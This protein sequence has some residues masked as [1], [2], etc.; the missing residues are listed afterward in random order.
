M[1]TA[2][3]QAGEIVGDPT[4][5]SKRGLVNYLAWLAREWPTAYA[6]LLKKLL[7]LTIK[8]DGHVGVEVLHALRGGASM[9]G[10]SSIIDVSPK[11]L[12]HP[13]ETD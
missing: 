4:D 6:G 5:E 7:P 11:A 8:S 13:M 1:R 9:N 10:H 3:L 2:I 12:P